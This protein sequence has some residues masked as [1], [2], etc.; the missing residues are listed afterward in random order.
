MSN[1]QK[2]ADKLAKRTVQL[3]GFG[4]FFILLVVKLIVPDVD[5]PWWVLFGFFGAGMS[6]DG[7]I[8][9]RLGSR[10]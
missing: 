7:D 4:T 1:K 3:L 2:R 6:A 5:I 10:K 8:I 9:E